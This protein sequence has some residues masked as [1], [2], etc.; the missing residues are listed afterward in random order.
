M[1]N[2]ELIFAFMYDDLESDL[3]KK[4]IGKLKYK[5]NVTTMW[6]VL[7][8]IHD[9]SQEKKEYWSEWAKIAMALYHID[10]DKLYIAIISFI[11][12]YNN[13]KLKS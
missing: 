4:I 5:N 13:L 11:N 3:Q 1:T 8:K 12:F 9:I 2:E 7:K 10:E 6:Q